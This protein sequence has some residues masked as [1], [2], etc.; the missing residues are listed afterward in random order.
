MKCA[1][2]V[3]ADLLPRVVTLASGSVCAQPADQAHAEEEWD[4]PAEESEIDGQDDTP[5]TENEMRGSLPR[6]EATAK[7]WPVAAPLKRLSF[8]GQ[9]IKLLKAQLNSAA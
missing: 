4:V 9:S 7:R 3:D 5:F 8:R 2:N 6:A 1:H